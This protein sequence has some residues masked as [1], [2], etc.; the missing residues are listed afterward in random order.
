M[1]RPQ[2]ASAHRPQ[3]K[4]MI[5]HFRLAARENFNHANAEECDG[6]LLCASTSIVKRA[7]MPLCNIVHMRYAFIS[8]DDR[9]VFIV[10]LLYHSLSLSLSLSYSPMARPRPLEHVL[11][12]QSGRSSV[13][14]KLCC[15]LGQNVAECN[16]NTGASL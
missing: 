6:V 13:M 9:N 4:L 12:Q 16:V 15:N 10:L 2:C 5:A 7:K 3:R 14:S 8:Y 11:E 1:E